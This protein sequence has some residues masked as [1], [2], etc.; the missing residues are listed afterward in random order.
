MVKNGF[1]I[2]NIFLEIEKCEVRCA[3][4]HL[5]KTARDFRWYQ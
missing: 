5:I 3:N 1:S 4:C 2:E